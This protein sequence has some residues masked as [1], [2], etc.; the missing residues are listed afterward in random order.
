[1]LF[2]M[3]IPNLD[4]G[5][6]TPGERLSG[7]RRA[8]GWS[9]H[10]LLVALEQA[11]EAHQLPLASRDAMKVTISRWENGRQI[12]DGAHRRLLCAV[13]EVSPKEI[14]FDSADERPGLL[15]AAGG[16]IPRPVTPEVTSYFEEVLQQYIRADHG[17]GPSQV[18]GVV[19]EQVTQL[20][21]LC[22]NAAEPGRTTLLRLAARYCE[23]LGWLCQDSGD[24]AEATRWTA[25]ANELAQLVDD[26]LLASYIAMRRAGILA[27]V[28]DGRASLGFAGLA[29]RVTRHT[30]PRLLAL[31]NRQV[32]GAYAVIG[33]ES[34]CRSAVESA[35]S[36]VTET[37]DELADLTGYC[38]PA[39][40]AMESAVSLAK[41][42]CLKNADDL[43]TRAV[44]TWPDGQQR[45]K[46]LCLAR[47]A[48]IRIADGDVAGACEAATDA[49]TIYVTAPS[50]RT[51]RALRATRNRLHPHRRAPEAAQLRTRLAA[52]V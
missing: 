14:G 31:I 51:A 22:G 6:G 36:A 20:D 1:M 48:E 45:D 23:F 41:L 37:D 26:P 10:Q 4:I 2:D 52:V 19:R 29:L 39:Y 32:A 34:R 24:L 44:A 9:Q 50:A 46:G 40:I 35:L 12:P 16:D 8:R 15:T 11:A 25:R 27:D 47:L 18:R 38:S 30:P 49:A 43:M 3:S 42:G 33:D 21:S 7:M 5:S 28:G 13:F 17:L